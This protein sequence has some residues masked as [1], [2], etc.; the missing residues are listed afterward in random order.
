MEACGIDVYT[1][2]RSNGFMIEVLQ[3]YS[4]KIHYFGLILIE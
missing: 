4:A 3:D 2:V 1:T